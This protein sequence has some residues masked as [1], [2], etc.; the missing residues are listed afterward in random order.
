MSADLSFIRLKYHFD[1]DENGFHYYYTKKDDRLWGIF[2]AGPIRNMPGA[3][4]TFIS[5][6]IYQDEHFNSTIY[7]DAVMLDYVYRF[8][9]IPP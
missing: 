9:I 3:W 4:D 5:S 2:R 8:E 6:W 1:K 7:N